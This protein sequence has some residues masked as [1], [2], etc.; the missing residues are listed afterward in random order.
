[1]PTSVI[2]TGRALPRRLVSNKEL[3]ESLNIRPDDIIR[4]TGVASR[5]WA[6]PD[7][8]ASSLAVEASLKALQ[9]AGLSAGAVDL[10]LVTTT[11]PDM[12]FPST[13]CLVQ[14]GLAELPG[15]ANNIP[16]F[17]INASCSGFIYALSIADQYLKSGEAKTVLVAATDVKSRFIDA[18]DLSTAILFGDGAGAVVLKNGPRGIRKIT[19]GAD[20]AHHQ[21]VHLPAGGSAL[22]MTLETLKTGR[23]FMSMAGKR[24]FRVAVRKMATSLS[25]FLAEAELQTDEIDCFVFHQANR[26]IL[27]A[28]FKRLEI[29]Q[30]KAALCLEKYG[31]TS[32]A[33]IP[34]ALDAALEAGKINAGDRVVFTA[35]G[36]G[37]TW[38][39]VLIDW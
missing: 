7:D 39:N 18:K 13:A 33:T 35:F 2:G 23:H 17:D 5:Y 26:R 21:L 11:T 20:G 6:G 22:P 24:L 34:V 37:V 9:S 1:M 15:G 19:L 31:N 8:T 14:K 36:G 12:Y 4:K 28:V 29:P 25:D 38:G 10:I 32:S 3:A 30:S 16:A 27:E